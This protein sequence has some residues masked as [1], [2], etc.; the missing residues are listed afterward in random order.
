MI[1]DSKYDDDGGGSGGALKI[2][3]LKITSSLFALFFLLQYH[4]RRQVTKMYKDNKIMIT[5]TTSNNIND[6]ICRESSFGIEHLMTLCTVTFLVLSSPYLVIHLN[7]L[8]MRMMMM[9]THKSIE[10]SSRKESLGIFLPHHN[11]ITTTTKLH[12]LL[13]LLTLLLSFLYC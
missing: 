4:H 5:T 2:H 6:G 10:F 12:T 13:V 9:H 11:N 8:M 3:A 7:T 1:Y